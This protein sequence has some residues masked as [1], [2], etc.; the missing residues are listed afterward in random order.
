MDFDEFRL[1]KLVTVKHGVCYGLTNSYVDSKSGFV[2]DSRG[3]DESRNCSGGFINSLDAAGQL[4][5]SR[6]YSHS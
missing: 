6:L 3:S 5:F 2:T 4:E 1:I